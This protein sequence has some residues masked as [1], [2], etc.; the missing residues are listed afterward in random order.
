M[1][2]SRCLRTLVI[3]AAIVLVAGC[4]DSKVDPSTASATSAPSVASTAPASTTAASSAPLS[5]TPAPGDPPLTGQILFE[6]S[7]SDLSGSQLW[8]E[9]ADGSSVR[10]V[11]K[12]DSF[13]GSGSL[14]PDGTRIVFGRIFTDSVEAAVADPRLFGALTLM[15][16]D[17]ADLHEIDTGDRAKL[18]DD[19]PEGDAWS[20]DGTRLAYVRYCFDR[21]ARPVEAG[22]STINADGTDARRVTKRCPTPVCR[23]TA[24]PVTRREDLVFEP[25][26]ASIPPERA[27][28]FT[29]GT[30][31]TDLHQVTEWSV[32]GNDPDWSPDGTEIVFNASAEPSPTQNIWTIHPDGS[33]L[34]QLTKYDQDHQATFHP[35]WSPDGAHL[36][37]SHSPSAPDGTGDLCVMD[38]DGANRHPIALTPITRTT[39]SG[40][41]PGVVGRSA[42]HRP[43][44]GRG[45]RACC[46]G[47]LDRRRPGRRDRAPA[48]G[49]EPEADER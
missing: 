8:L 2:A 22:V 36:L 32:D 20:P 38:R 24:R 11:L 21:Q 6:D 14:S 43:W 48:A 1:P 31:G 44:G 26:D 40:E 39:P 4:A 37:F 3:A 46:G 9:N 5:S 28:I 23:S 29:V 10:Q 45:F 18:C 27:A 33:G 17:G 15:N 42:V 25:I 30:D 16:T 41:Q 7:G 19:A 13:D 34:T 12:D 47:R 35:T 49:D